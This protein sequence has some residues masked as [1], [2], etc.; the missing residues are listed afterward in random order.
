M[1]QC[2]QNFL[3]S[4]SQNKQL[5]FH[6]QLGSSSVGEQICIPHHYV[7]S[8]L[9]ETVGTLPELATL[10]PLLKKCLT[11]CP[12]VIITNVIHRSQSYCLVPHT[13]KAVG[14]LCLESSLLKQPSVSS[15]SWSKKGQMFGQF[16]RNKPSKR[17]KSKCVSFS[18]THSQK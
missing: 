8:S 16:L 10:C 4:V 17:Y 6:F 5:L 13:P 2:V 9:A 18:V 11:P 15:I 12:K 7:N 3:P 1:I 14:W